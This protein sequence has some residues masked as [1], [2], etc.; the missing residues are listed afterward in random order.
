MVQREKF[1]SFAYPS[2]YLHVLLERAGLLGEFKANRLACEYCDEP[3]GEINI[4]GVFLDGS[5]RCGLAVCHKV[6]CIDKAGKLDLGLPML[7]ACL[8]QH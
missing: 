1:C 8:E 6:D 2:T 7:C 5:S 4:G 3:L